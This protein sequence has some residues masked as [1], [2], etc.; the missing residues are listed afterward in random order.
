MVRR[1]GLVISPFKVRVEK[2]HLEPLLLIQVDDGVI[3]AQQGAV[4]C[5]RHL[6]MVGLAIG[7]TT[8]GCAHQSLVT[9]DPNG[10]FEWVRNLSKCRPPFVEN[11]GEQPQVVNEPIWQEERRELDGPL[12]IQASGDALS[13]GHQLA[14]LTMVARENRVVKTVNDLTFIHELGP[15]DW[16]KGALV[17]DVMNQDGGM[18]NAGL[19]IIGGSQ[20]LAVET[21][22]EMA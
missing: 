21:Q 16:F 14:W 11:L 9:T 8:Q 5:W 12:P 1:A 22:D 4:H 10:V 15:I 13:T 2:V 7:V 20:C 19:S 6:D 17:V 3:V 18:L